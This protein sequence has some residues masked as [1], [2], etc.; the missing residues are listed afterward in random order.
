MNTCSPLAFTLVV[1][2]LLALMPRTDST[3]AI[4]ATTAAGATVL[5]LTA[6]QVTGIAALG[7]LVKAKAL[8]AGYL[9]TR[10]RG[11]RSAGNG[12]ILNLEGLVEE[13]SEHCFKRS[14][15]YAATGKERSM[16]PLLVLLESWLPQV[17]RPPSSARLLC[18]EI[19]LGAWRSAS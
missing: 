13:E 9:L 14:F 1:M 5:S 16:A 18:W 10:N 11:R 12:L 8:L 4:T 7:V 3:F 19:G 17:Q 6:A 15:C 2:S